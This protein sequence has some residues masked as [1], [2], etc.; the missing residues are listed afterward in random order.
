MAGDNGSSRQGTRTGRVAVV[1]LGRVGLPFALAMAEAGFPVIGV[2]VDAALVERIL[3]RETPFQEDGLA[4]YMTRYVGHGFEPTTD[5]R[6]LDG[7]DY[8]VI[9]VGTPVDDNLNPVLTD[10]LTVIDTLAP[11]VRRGQ[12]IIL[13]STMSPGTTARVCRYLEQRS[14]LQIE[15]DIF[16]AACPERI[17]EGRAFEEMRTI[18]QLVGGA[19]PAST[20]RAA[21]LFAALDVE[22]LETDALSA[23]IAKLFTNMYRY[24][25][26]ALANEFFMVAEQYGRSYSEIRRLVN[27]GY[28]RGGLASAGL[29]AGPCLYKDGFFLLDAVPYTELITTSWRINENLPNFLVSLLERQRPLAGARVALLG[30]A[31]KANID[32]T[33]QSLSFRLQKLL[34]AREATVLAH[35]PY[36]ARYAGRALAEVVEEADIVIIAVPHDPYLEELPSMLRKRAGI[37]VCDVWNV[38]GNGRTLF[39]GEAL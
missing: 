36:V 27:H 39:G 20:A 1:G 16:V 30:M 23:E 3:R 37:L 17:A 8:V 18:P 38:C 2:D 12:T 25:Q 6:Q 22:T 21:S 4:D 28:A 32:D 19:G 31:F 35:D 26:F 7:V 9:T 33:R 13:R 11:F 10:I 24:V 15:K 29:A 14:G 34:R 5:A